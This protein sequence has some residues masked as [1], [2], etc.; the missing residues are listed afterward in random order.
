M[1]PEVYRALLDSWK[2]SLQAQRMSK[3]T[4]KSYTTG[5]LQFMA[6]CAKQGI[7][8]GLSKAG[9]N[10]FVAELTEAGKE[11]A[12]VRAR[13]LS[14]RRF[15]AWLA[16]ED[17][18]ERD[19]LLGLKPPKLDSKMV[20][21][22]SDE[23]LTALFA[24][25]HGKTFRDRR[26]E[27]LFRLMA[28]AFTRATE[29]IDMTISGTDVRRGQTLIVRGK[30]GKGRLVFFGPQT[31]QALD[32]YLR[33]R[34]THRLAGTDT[35]WLGNGGKGFSY[36]ALH[37][38]LKYRARLAG[39]HD[40]HPHRLRHTGATRWLRKG[41]SEGGL[42]EAAGWA[43]RDMIDRYTRATASERAAAEAR[44]LNLGDL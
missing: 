14:V 29:T 31:A 32:R 21:P 37:W 1:T 10:A 20:Q 7:D 11:A 41:G 2:L 44:S 3:E 6:W 30:G 13:Q 16:E 12:T 27:A 26:D 24:A 40:A 18:I 17:E 9:V 34:R 35:F 33:L 22:Y 15:S 5:A 4:L 39:L 8:P 23:E 36:S 25:C 28:E 43:T 19:E 42:M 38:T